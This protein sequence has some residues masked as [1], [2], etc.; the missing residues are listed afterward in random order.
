MIPY[1]TLA[2]WYDELMG[3]VPYDEWGSRILYLLDAM[4]PQ[5][6]RILE[7]ACGTGQITGQLLKAGHWVTAVDRSEAMLQEA[8][9]QLGNP[10]AKLKLIAADMLDY[11]TTERYDA[12]I[13]VCDG[14]NYLASLKDLDSMLKKC[15]ELCKPGGLILFDLSSDWKFR[16]QLKDTV[17]AENHEDMAFIW[18]NHYDEA[19]RLLEFDLTFFIRQGSTF[20]RVTEHHVQRA[21][22]PEEIAFICREHKLDLEG[23]FD[24]YSAS[25]VED[26]SERFHCIIRNGGTA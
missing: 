3:E 6:K 9:K 16:T 2:A 26:E 21:H 11:A 23:I 25:P 10:G 1:D 12:V 18:E 24:G 14:F 7:L 19:E 13:S 15:R 8:Q 22:T 17:I 4:G 5:P 20:R